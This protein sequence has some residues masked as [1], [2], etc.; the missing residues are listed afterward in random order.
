MS[1]FILF[2][3]REYSDETAALATLLNKDHFWSFFSVENDPSPEQL[4]ANKHSNNVKIVSTFEKAVWIF[5]CV[6]IWHMSWWLELF[7]LHEPVWHTSGKSRVYQHDFNQNLM[8]IIILVS[9][10]RRE[11]V[12]SATLLYTVALFSQFK[13]KTSIKVTNECILILSLGKI[14]SKA[15]VVLSLRTLRLLCIR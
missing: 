4:V 9:R 6:I 15:S 2:L 7:F 11:L 5:S 13:W 12:S 3:Y 8:D 1:Q 10:H 14:S